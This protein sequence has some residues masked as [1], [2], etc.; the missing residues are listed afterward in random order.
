[1]PRRATSVIP[2][3]EPKNEESSLILRA[4]DGHGDALEVLIERHTGIYDFMLN[5]YSGS[6]IPIFNDLKDDR[7]YNM[8]Q[9]IKDYDTSSSMKLSTY[10]GQRT[11][12]LCLNEIRKASRNEQVFVGA[13]NGPRNTDYQFSGSSQGN[14]KDNDSVIPYGG[15]YYSYQSDSFESTMKNDATPLNDLNIDREDA[16][17]ILGEL[18]RLCNDKRFI[19]IFTLRHFP[20]Q[21]CRTTCLPWRGVAKEI[22]LSAQMSL[23]IYNKNKWIV[24]NILR[25]EHIENCK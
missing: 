5:K 15:T 6:G 4:Q 16:Q 9:F 1:M 25:N 14:Q 18:K 12:F 11:K 7:T 19:T 20:P 2:G 21:D 17:F 23:N 3:Q 8:Y 22:G 13:I 10:I 24:E